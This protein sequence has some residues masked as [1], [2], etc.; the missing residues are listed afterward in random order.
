[1]SF[2]M[3]H[4]SMIDALNCAINY[5][6]TNSIR[7][8]ARSFV[9]QFN[10][11]NFPIWTLT[12]DSIPF[13]LIFPRVQVYFLSSPSFF[14]HENIIKNFIKLA[15]LHTHTYTFINTLEGNETSLLRCGF[16]LLLCINI[17][18]WWWAHYHYHAFLTCVFLVYTKRRIKWA[19]ELSEREKNGLN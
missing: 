2:N 5:Q 12:F 9:L 17:Y 1:M 4:L 3:L 18:S 6:F 10:N 15:Q 7:L 13:K 19:E 16:H 11:F 14:G 8:F